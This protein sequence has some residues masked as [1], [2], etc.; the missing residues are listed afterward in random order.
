[1]AQRDKHIY[2]GRFEIFTGPMYS[3]KTEALEAALKPLQYSGITP[4][5]FNPAINNRT[6]RRMDLETIDVDHENPE[7]IL[8]YVKDEHNVIAFEEVELFGLDKESGEKIN[9]SLVSIIDNLM[10]KNKYVL[11][12][13][14]DLNFRG[15]T[16]GYMGDFLSMASVVHKM[17]RAVCAYQDCGNVAERTIRLID[18]KPAHYSSPLIMIEGAD[19]N[20]KYEPRCLSHHPVPGKPKHI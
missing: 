16:F 4:I 20:V 1:M 3:G 10:R 9:G 2:P 7:E 18:D 12:A 19:K 17:D 14:G 13:G 11:A 8:K 15:E 6:E 5:V